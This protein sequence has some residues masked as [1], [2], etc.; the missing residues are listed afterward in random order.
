MTKVYIM[1]LD[2]CEILQISL[3]KYEMVVVCL[4]HNLMHEKVFKHLFF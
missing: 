1:E 3:K 2:L 4:A